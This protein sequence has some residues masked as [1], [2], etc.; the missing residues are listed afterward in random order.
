MPLT[1]ANKAKANWLSGLQKLQRRD[2]SAT[3]RL[4]KDPFAGDAGPDLDEAGAHLDVLDGLGPLDSPLKDPFSA[5]EGEKEGATPSG[6]I[7]KDPFPEDPSTGPGQSPLKDPFSAEETEK[8]GATPSGGTLKDPFPEDPS[9][10]PGKSPLKDPFSE[11]DTD[12]EGAAPAQVVPLPTLPDLP[13]PVVTLLRD[14]SAVVHGG[15]AVLAAHAALQDALKTEHLGHD[16]AQD[17]ADAAV[18]IQEAFERMQDA[19]GTLLVRSNDPDAR[20]ALL[21][22]IKG[23]GATQDATAGAVAKAG[24]VVVFPKK[25]QITV[26]TGQ[27]VSAE[28]QK[29]MTTFLSEIDKYTGLLHA[30][31]R[32]VDAALALFSV[33]K[34]FA[35]WEARAD[36]LR[37]DLEAS[38]EPLT[39]ARL[40]EINRTAAEKGIK[41]QLRHINRLLMEIQTTF[42]GGRISEMEAVLEAS[43]D[44][45]LP[46]NERQLLQVVQQALARYQSTAKEMVRSR[47][48]ELARL[49]QALKD[50]LERRLKGRLDLD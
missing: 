42:L 50:E 27:P 36:A 23:V 49:H 18:R 2:N 28:N 46:A 40:T 16:K 12:K 22:A 21:D 45:R 13:S 9:T 6:G 37:K 31:T 25:Q 29:K 19:L 39:A 14:P 41:D 48:A 47:R 35:D 30:K 17:N 11:E 24:L 20:G 3:E 7:L 32:G 38:G 44:M 15:D 26:L 10:G 8:E 33:E 4:L 43:E 5:E 34:V 1:P